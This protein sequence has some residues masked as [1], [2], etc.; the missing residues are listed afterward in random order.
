MITGQDFRFSF[1]VHSAALKYLT[2]TSKSVKLSFYKNSKKNGFEELEYQK[3]IEG[4]FFEYF[5]LDPED[6]Y[7]TVPSEQCFRPVDGQRIQMGG[8][9]ETINEAYFG[10]RLD[11]YCSGLPAECASIKN[12]TLANFL[13]LINYNTYGVYLNENKYSPEQGKLISGIAQN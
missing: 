1:C 9:Y 12:T 4:E 10:V 7:G 8:S 2:G 11:P 5:Q 3:M 6:P 13:K